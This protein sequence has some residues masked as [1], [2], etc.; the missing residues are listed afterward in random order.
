MTI[1]VHR[2]L[3]LSKISD[4]GSTKVCVCLGFL[5]IENVTIVLQLSVI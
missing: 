5:K 2:T 4:F 3:K 1:K